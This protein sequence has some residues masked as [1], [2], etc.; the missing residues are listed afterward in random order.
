MNTETIK[1]TIEAALLCAG[2]PMELNE[3]LRMFDEAERPARKRKQYKPRSAAPRAQAT[4]PLACAS[5]LTG[6]VVKWTKTQQYDVYVGRPNPRIC[7]GT[8]Y[9][10]WGNPFKLASEADREQVRHVLVS[11][12]S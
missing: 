2:R 8:G 6:L 9:C 1:N 7:T 12:C 3:L 10:K 11:P 5:D 4:H